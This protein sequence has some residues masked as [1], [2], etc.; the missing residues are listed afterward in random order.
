MNTEKLM[1]TIETRIEDAK[2]Y[3]LSTAEYSESIYRHNIDKLNEASGILFVL[4]LDFAPVNFQEYRQTIEGLIVDLERKIVQAKGYNGWRNY[5]TW[6]AA[7]W[8]DNDYGLYT[9]VTEYAN[10]ECGDRAA[11]AKYL[12]S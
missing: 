5:E 2:R 10:E 1:N 12:E 7:L 3:T 6:N 11:M 4:S 9:M 8:I